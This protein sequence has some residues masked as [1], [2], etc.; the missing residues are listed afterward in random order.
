MTTRRKRALVTAVVVTAA[1]GIVVG[2]QITSSHRSP[3]TVTAQFDSAAGLY[4]GNTVAVLGIPVGAVTKI[5]PKG[6]YVEVEFTVDPDVQLPAD[7]KAVTINTSILTDRQIELTPPYHGGPLLADHGVIGLPRTRTPVAFDRVLDMLDKISKSLKGDDAGHGP[8]AD[9]ITAAADITEGN[10][11]KIKAALG[12]LSDALRLSADRGEAT[13]D[14]M[15]TIVKDLS[16]LMQAA[17]SSDHKIRQLG[18]STHQLSQIIADEDFGSGATGHIINEIVDQAKLLVDQN[19]EHLKQVIG[20]GE[21]AAKT[22]VDRQRELSEFIDVLPLALENLY[23]AIDQNN[24][25][26]RAH[27]LAD[28]VLTDAQSTK[29]ICNMMHLRQLGCSTGTLQDYGPDFG[30]TYV[31]DGLAAMGQ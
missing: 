4:D 14:Q 23:N 15:T 12:D 11:D 5:S 2:A 16:S 25:A 28:K 7:V 20:N 18:A 26:V 21:V 13:R 19:R 17:A 8:V 29:E 6:S 27:L 9:L 24:G 30:L 1:A 10:G 31:L 22:T 3:I